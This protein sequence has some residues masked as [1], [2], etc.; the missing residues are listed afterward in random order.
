MSLKE[1][2][3][4]NAELLAKIAELQNTI[5]TNDAA[6][7]INQSQGIALAAHEYGQMADFVRSVQKMRFAQKFVKPTQAPNKVAALAERQVDETIEKD[8]FFTELVK[9]Y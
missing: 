5:A 2:Q 4:Q 3:K 9:H 1:L 6:D 7:E 8:I